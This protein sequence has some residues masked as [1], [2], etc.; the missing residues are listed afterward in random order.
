LPARAVRTP[1]LANYLD[2]EAKLQRL[3]K[4]KQCTVGFDCLHQCGLRD[5]IGKAGQFCID[6][7]LAFALEGDEK[8]GL[9]FRGSEPLPFGD[10]VRPVSELI[11]YMLN[12]AR[13]TLPSEMVAATMDV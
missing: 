10:Q 12:G 2:K 6:T 8:R 13:P 11:D 7:Q 9:F 4:P 3:A 1:W 5:G